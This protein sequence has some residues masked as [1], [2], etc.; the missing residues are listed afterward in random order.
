MPH[1]PGRLIPGSEKTVSGPFQVPYRDRWTVEWKT[2]SGQVV[3][4]SLDLTQAFPKPLAGY[5][6]FTIDKDQNLQ[7]LTEPFVEK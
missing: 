1:E 5:L 4:R 2:A 3:T 6:I 7:Y